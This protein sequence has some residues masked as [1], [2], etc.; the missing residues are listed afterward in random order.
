MPQDG[1]ATLLENNNMILKQTSSF[2]LTLRGDGIAILK[3]DVPGESSNTLRAEFTTE[4]N[5]ILAALRGETRVKGIVITSGKPDSF[6]VGADINMLKTIERP[7]QAEQLSGEGHKAMF[8]LQALNVPLVAAVHG[9]AL[10]GGLELAL[11]CHER[12]LSD[13]NKTIVGLPEVQLGVLPG[14]GGTQRLPKLIGVANAL[15]MMLTGKQVRAKQAL[16]MGLA[17]EVVP[18]ATLESAAVKRALKLVNHPN[19]D[20]LLRKVRKPAPALSG[21]GIM[22]LLLESNPIGRSIIFSQ[23]RKAAAAKT[24]GNYPSPDKIIDCVAAA[25]GNDGFA[26]EARKFGELVVTPVAR[27]LMNIFFATTALKKDKVTDAPAHEIRKVGVLG[28]GLMGAGIAFISIDKAKVK[29]RV[30]DRDDKGTGHA[31]KYAHEIL[32]GRAKKKHMTQAAA[33]KLL[34]QLTVATDFSG[35]KDMDIVIEAV[36]EDLTLKQQMVK[37]IET[38]CR[39][40]TIFATNTSSIPISSIAEGAQRP[41]HIIGMH[42]FSPV[43][44]MPLLEIITTDQTADWVTSTAVE[45]GRAQGKT[46]IVVKDKAGF[47]VNRILAPYMN[48]AGYLVAAGV[49]VDLVDKAL[50]KLGFPIG[51]INLLD[52]VGIDVG[53]KVAPI[54]AAAFGDRMNPPAAFSKLLAD[55]R[56]GKKNKRGFYLYTDSGKGKKQVDSSVYAL[57]GVTPDAQVEAGEIAERCLLMMVNEAARCLD[58]GII[59]SARDG[60]IGAIFGIGFPPYL[61]GPFRYVDSYGA[62]AIV[63]RMQHYQRECGE[64]FTPCERLLAMAAGDERFYS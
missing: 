15:D 54:L 63:E 62:K 45:F 53:T 58:E 16:K 3:M 11:C 56:L 14:G 21:P 32:S 61:G 39:P 46:V 36:F 59:R 26:T 57:L 24:Y 1:E 19:R 27:Q 40:D 17:D 38:N 10:G 37:D 48:E 18:K 12:V 42:Y 43:E 20:G 4:F 2:T 31:V 50:K 55:N 60:D 35:F 47:Y 29:A 51:P 44:K 25:F 6:V 5:E 28:G 23:A 49:P 9:P 30:K 8:D 34:S 64:R 41:E 7:E 22:R 13:D 33:G 52:E